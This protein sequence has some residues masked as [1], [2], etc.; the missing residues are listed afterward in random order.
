MKRKRIFLA[1][2]IVCLAVCAS[3]LVWMLRPLLPDVISNMEKIQ[4]PTSD[5][6]DFSAL[7]AENPDIYAWLYIPGTDISHPVL[8]HEKEGE[9]YLSHNSAGDPSEDGALF[10]QAAYNSRDFSDPATIIYG[11]RTDTNVMFGLL[12]QAYSD[13]EDFS[14]HEEI[15]IYQEGR[16][17]VYSVFAATPYDDRHI[18]YACQFTG[19]MPPLPR[20]DLIPSLRV[21][22]DHAGICD[23]SLLHTGDKLDH[24]GV[25]VSHQ[26]GLVPGHDALEGGVA[27]KRV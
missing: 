11:H 26:I 4:F 13:P 19:P 18:L 27:L 6:I 16:T 5:S 2:G 15:R 17:L 23:P 7:R 8:Q 10:T 22:A 12:Q 24:G 25:V 14:Q 21:R 9:Y 3:C 1:A 20:N